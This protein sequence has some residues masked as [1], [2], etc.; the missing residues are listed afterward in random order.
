[1]EFEF[2]GKVW[3]WRGPAPW[4]FVTIPEGFS[5]DIR[6]I[7]SLVSYGWGV[8][9]VEVRIGG[10]TWETSLFPKDERY[11]VPIRANVRKAER[12]AEDDDVTVTLR[13]HVN[14]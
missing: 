6:A 11:I 2:S 10:T 12:I 4:Y 8:I 3:F 14:L 1:M 5:Q 9:P 13:L 7:A